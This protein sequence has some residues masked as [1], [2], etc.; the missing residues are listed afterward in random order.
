[1]SLLDRL[2]DLPDRLSKLVDLAARRSH[3]LGCVANP[4]LNRSGQ[5]VTAG[6]EQT[7]ARHDDQRSAYRGRNS[8][9]CQDINDRSE[10]S[11][12]QQ[13]QCYRDE[14]FLTKVERGS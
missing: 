5:K 10:Q 12:E 2:G 6:P 8:E 4:P 9:A 3:R 7:Q 13:T 1:L 14:H 11:S